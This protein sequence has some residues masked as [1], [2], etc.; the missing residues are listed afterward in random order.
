MSGSVEETGDGEQPGIAARDVPAPSLFGL[1][2]KAAGVSTS[3]AEMFPK[4]TS[5]SLKIRSLGDPL[6]S[7]HVQSNFTVM[8]G[9]QLA[10]LLR[11]VLTPVIQRLMTTGFDVPLP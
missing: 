3:A 9:D 11:A 4:A 2:A 7:F 1:A 6:K 5:R 8:L 10:S